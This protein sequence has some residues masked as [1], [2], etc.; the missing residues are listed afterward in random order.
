M[1]AFQDKLRRYEYSR[2]QTRQI[3]EASIRGFHNKLRRGAIHI[4]QACLH[5]PAGRGAG[6]DPVQLY[7]VPAKRQTAGLG[8]WRCG[9]WRG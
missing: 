1:E 6:E 4:T 7:V 3:M 5:H 8:G 9:G 2:E